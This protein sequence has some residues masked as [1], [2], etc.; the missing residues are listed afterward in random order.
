MAPLPDLTPKRS[1]KKTA[2]LCHRKPSIFYKPGWACKMKGQRTWPF[3]KKISVCLWKETSSL[4]L[5]AGG[6]PGIL[7]HCTLKLVQPSTW[8]DAALALLGLEPDSLRCILSS[9]CN[10]L[11]ARCLCAKSSSNLAGTDVRLWPGT[12]GGA[13]PAQLADG[14]CLDSPLFPG[15]WTLHVDFPQGHSREHS[16]GKRTNSPSYPPAPGLASTE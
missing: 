4:R 16:L 7:A 8:R 1:Q 2:V 13:K 5:G 14:P 3:P 12:V 15:N 11:P 9:A 10:C 6:E